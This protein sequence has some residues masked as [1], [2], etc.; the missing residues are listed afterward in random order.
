MDD[1]LL[2]SARISSFDGHD[3][4]KVANGGN[5]IFGRSIGKENLWY[6][7]K[8]NKHF[9]SIAPTRS[10]KGAALIIPNL[11]VY[12][13][14]SIV[15]DPKG[16][17]AYVTAEARRKMGQKTHILDPWGETNRRYGAKSGILEEV[18]T[19]NPLSILDPASEHFADDI[20]Y[21]ADS[22]II[23]QGKD[24]HWDDSARELVAGLI[25]Y[26]VTKFGDAASLPLVRL[27]LTKP[28]EE[29]AGI[30][31]EAQGFGVYNIAARKLGRFA[32]ESKELGSIISTALTQ[33]AFLDSETL[34]KNLENSSFSFEDLV[35]G[36]STIYLVLPVDK[37]QTYGRW[38]RLMVSIGIRTIARNTRQLY[39]PVLFFL[40]EFG[41]IG[42]LSAVSQAVGLMAGLQMCIWVFVQD[43]IQLKRDYPNEWETFIANAGYI[44]TFNIMDQ[45]TAEYV[46]KMLGQTTVERISVGTAEARKKN[47]NYGG[48]MTDQAFSRAL[49]TADEVRTMSND[50]GFLLSNFDPIIF[51]KALYFKDPAFVGLY[52]KN[53]HF[54]DTE[55]KEKTATCPPLTTKSKARW[56][57]YF[58]APIFGVGFWLFLEAMG[59]HF[60]HS[61]N[62][63]PLL[64]CA[65]STGFSWLLL[66]SIF[67]KKVTV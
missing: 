65:A 54:P 53:P 43:L 44:S 35:N 15:I 55:I 29:I 36:E 58:L 38:L 57:T 9:V 10:G 17:N 20:A 5:V 34:G 3:F 28:P 22:V 12:K 23:S 47:P 13:G 50:R 45:F 6:G 49:A 37:L 14:S 4:E 63:V 62:V 16:E 31:Q 32:S 61:S 52:R 41:T 27:L 66:A 8:V 24:P 2:G 59:V 67:R 40:D 18:A 48:K 26:A 21:L 11:L 1:G 64:L 51:A 39:L 33:T 19:F 42:K 46:S 56:W 25:A 30:A 60:Y 7:S